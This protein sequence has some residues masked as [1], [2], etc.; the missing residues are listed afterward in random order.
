MLS[1]MAG[2]QSVSR[3]KQQNKPLVRFSGKETRTSD[4]A[5]LF[6]PGNEVVVRMLAK[7]KD[8]Q[9]EYVRQHIVSIEPHHGEVDSFGSSVPS[10]V[11]AINDKVDM[12]TLLDSKGAITRALVGDYLM[13]VGQDG[14]KDL[15]DFKFRHENGAPYGSLEM[16]GG[17]AEPHLI[18]EYLS[19][20]DALALSASAETSFID[21]IEGLS[22]ANLRLT[23]ERDRLAE[24]QQRLL[25]SIGKLT[26]ELAAKIQ[27]GAKVGSL[28]GMLA[29]LQALTRKD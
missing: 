27:K 7:D 21:T 1:A 15:F 5:R 2:N 12:V 3:F 8:Y 14:A 20:E 22:A 19:I 29:Q 23:Q 25:Q 18:Q 26:N 17:A 16:N 13:S 11:L 10:E 24:E 9:G 6:N 4:F 28:K